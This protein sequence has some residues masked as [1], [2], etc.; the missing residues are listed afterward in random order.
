MNSMEHTMK[1]Y[2]ENFKDTYEDVESV[3]QDTYSGYYTEEET[4]ESGCVVF[5]VKVLQKIKK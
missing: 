4:K 5:T 2:A 3:V 1:L